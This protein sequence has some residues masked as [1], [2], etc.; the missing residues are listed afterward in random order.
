[1][2][3]ATATTSS[4]GGPPVRTATP[5]PPKEVPEPATMLLMGAGLAGLA[6]L[7]RRRSA[8]AD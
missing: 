1:V 3:G 7:R 5:E 2:G 4:G 6:A 8:S